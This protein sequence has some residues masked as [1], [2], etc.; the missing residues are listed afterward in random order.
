VAEARAASIEQA[1]F[2]QGSRKTVLLQRSTTGELLHTLQ[3]EQPLIAAFSA[4]SRTVAV[5]GGNGVVTLFDVETGDKRA[6]LTS[7]AAGLGC[8]CITPDGKYVLAA[9]TDRTLVVWDVASRRQLLKAYLFLQPACALR[10]LPGG[11]VIAS[12]TNDGHIRFWDLQ[13][14]LAAVAR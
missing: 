14:L 7:N 1:R 6:E 8:L 13:R 11:R 10:L 12:A 5:G 2:M 9:S 4:D 3:V